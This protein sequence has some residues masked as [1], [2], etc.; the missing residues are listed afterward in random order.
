MTRSLSFSALVLFIA[1]AFTI[2]ATLQS[3]TSYDLVP[4]NSTM[5]VDGTSTLHDWSCPVESMTGSFQ[6]DTSATET[7]P[8]S[9]LRR[10]HVSVPVD[11]IVCDKDT[12]NEKLQE[13]LQSNAYPKVMYTLQSVDLQPLADSSDS[14]FEAQTTGE[15]ILAGER[16]SID[17]AVKGQRMDDGRMRFVGQ[18]TLKLSDY[19]V[20]RPSAL[21]GTIKTGNEITVRFDVVAAP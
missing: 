12:M 14:W 13:A 2:G 15:L 9:T 18:H 6:I 7:T 21:L 1:G 20:D 3:S 10:V 16:Q 11:Q 19:N 17:M 8:I 5:H 4:T